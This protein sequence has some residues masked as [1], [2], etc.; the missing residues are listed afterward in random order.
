MDPRLQWFVE[1][2]SRDLRPPPT[3]AS[4]EGEIAVIA[5]VAAP[6]DW[7]AM[8]DVGR[9]RT[10]GA[11]GPEASIVTAT[12]PVARIEAVRQAP[13]VLSMKPAQLLRPMLGATIE[14]IAARP[15][16]LPPRTQGNGGA[17][18]IVGLVDVGC[19]IAHRNFRKPDGS[20]RIL[21]LWNQAA[22]S[23]PGAP[24]PFGRLYLSAE[25]DRA[26]QGADPYATLG[27]FP[28]PAS[29]GTHVMDVAA[30]NG[31]G[32]GVPGVAP[33]ADIVFVHAATADVPW[34]GVPVVAP[35]STDSALLLE[36]LGFI[37]DVAGARPCAVNVSFGTDGGPHDGTSLVEQGMDRLVREAPNRAIV[38]A[39]SNSYA[40]GIH[41]TVEIAGGLHQDL[42][43]LVPERD[44]AHGE[45]Q[46][47]Y[48]A[49]GVLRAELIAPDGGSSG[50]VDLGENAS[51]GDGPARIF[52]AHRQ[53]DPNNG[54]NVLGVFLER[55][56]RAG[57]WTVRLHGVTPGPCQVHA[58]I[59]RAHGSPS[60]F[61]PP[62][63]PRYTLGA[64]ACGRSVI[65]AGSYDAHRPG[66]PLSW[67]S[68]AGPTRD[69]RSKPEVSAPGQD[70]WA[71][72]AQTGKGSVRK[73][74]TSLAAPAVTG[75]AALMLAEARARGIDLDAN[76]IRAVLLYT[77]RETPP[78]VGWHDRYGEGRVDAHAAVRAIQKL[79]G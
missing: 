49:G 77:S 21:A 54:D 75:V 40:D 14:D 56:V 55:G 28:G 46:V 31:G 2:R 29:H 16:L 26:L 13:G 66:A 15:D 64:L 12:I 63:D 32:T 3:S 57:R 33:T 27:Y 73:S 20:T 62:H 34:D 11:Q 41:R 51:Y 71:A 6:G 8:T 24:V 7:F 52:L 36:A 42:V 22:P 50:I 25:I 78:S 18:V 53:N 74:G 10:I 1:R 70:V 60:A 45:L 48:A 69:G 38:V 58:W 65:A 61:E 17:G 35:E 30:G 23:T 76:Q 47:W 43:W 79:T 9:G 19:D 67:F 59:E 72:G 4:R 68:S 5:K 37:F 39:A 44:V